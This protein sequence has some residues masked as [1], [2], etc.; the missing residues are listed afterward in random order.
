MPDR[1]YL[2]LSIFQGLTRE[3]CCLLDPLIETCQFAKGTKIFEQGDA[4][5]YLYILSKGEAIVQYKPYDGP[6][7]VVAHIPVGG[8]FG[9][10][11]ILG[12]PQYTSG[13]SA[14]EDCEAYRLNGKQLLKSLEQSPDTSAVLL[15]R[16]T[17][18]VSERLQIS[19][20]QVLEILNHNLG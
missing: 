18:S 8:V 1:D 20:D 5:A 10:S 7:L 13:A 15:D 3:Q 6:T 12:R 17:A 14:V 16:L 9:W 11:T 19:R 2:N 4:A